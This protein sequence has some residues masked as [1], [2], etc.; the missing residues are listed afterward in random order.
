MARRLAAQESGESEEVYSA[1]EPPFSVPKQRSTVGNV[2]ELVT[3]VESKENGFLSGSSLPAHGSVLTNKLPPESTDQGDDLFESEDLFA[4][5]STTRTATQSKL[6]EEMPGSVANEPIKGMEKKPELSVLGNQDSSALFQ[7][8]QQKSSS[9][10]SPMSFL[11]E[12]EDSLFPSQKTGKE[13]L[14]SAV[15]QAVDS[16][17]QD[18]FEVMAEAC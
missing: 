11:E 18:I 8:V 1:K 5:R 15:Q 13:E 17:A 6:R 2:K 16:A 12:E 10:N 4:S 3:E 9:K 7:S 14:K